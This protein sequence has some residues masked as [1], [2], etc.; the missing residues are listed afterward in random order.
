MEV[1]SWM[2]C[3][4]RL[5]VGSPPGS[6]EGGPAVRE[7]AQALIDFWALDSH[8]AIILLGDASSFLGSQILVIKVWLAGG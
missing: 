7:G 2:F 5:T 3:V 6:S 4:G 8:V 1:Q